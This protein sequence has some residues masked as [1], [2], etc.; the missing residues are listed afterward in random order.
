MQHEAVMTFDPARGAAD[1]RSPS[2]E[3]RGVKTSFVE[4]VLALLWVALIVLL[5]PV[6]IL[7]AGLPIAALLRLL[8]E[9]GTWLFALS[10]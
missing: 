2:P 6:L 1:R 4:G 7:L 9:A 8:V 3:P 5:V 10:G